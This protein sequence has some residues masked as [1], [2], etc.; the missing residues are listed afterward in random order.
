MA[1]FPGAV[2]HFR[3]HPVINYLI[4]LKESRFA[5]QLREHPKQ[6]VAGIITIGTWQVPCPS[7][8]IAHML[9]SLIMS[10]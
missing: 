4:L 5:A 7:I 8:P 10:P 1:L 3:Y 6:N 2:K 9:V